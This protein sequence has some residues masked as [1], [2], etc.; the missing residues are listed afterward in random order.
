MEYWDT[1]FTTYIGF[2]TADDVFQSLV[3]LFQDE[4]QSP[5]EHRTFLRIKYVLSPENSAMLNDFTTS[6]IAAMKYWATNPNLTID[7]NVL[8]RI[9]EFAM[10]VRSSPRMTELANELHLVATQRV[11]MV[12]SAFQP[13]TLSHFTSL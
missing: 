4:E 13:L 10:S 5:V 12:F 7:T 8:S 3:R 1:F 2:T 11:W 6:I 9:Q